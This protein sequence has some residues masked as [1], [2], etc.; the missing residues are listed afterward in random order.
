MFLL[1][2]EISILLRII[3]CA[4]LHQ[5]LQMHHTNRYES[6]KAFPNHNFAV[7]SGFQKRNDSACYI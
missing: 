6:W 7:N 5:R 4:K 2:I 3:H 1:A